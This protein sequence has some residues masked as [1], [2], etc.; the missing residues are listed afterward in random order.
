VT[1]NIG[2]LKEFSARLRTLPTVV[3][4]KVAAEAAP[5]LTAAALAT[6]NAGTD[7]FGGSWKIREDGSR[8]TLKQSGTLFGKVRYVAIGTKLRVS[9]ATSYGKY[10]LGTRPVFPKQGQSLPPSY[11]AAL[12][13]ATAKVCKAELGR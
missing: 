12:Q 8:A 5:A 6:Y 11:V 2:S 7:A 1:G 3:A 10:V 9:L 4:Q 13:A